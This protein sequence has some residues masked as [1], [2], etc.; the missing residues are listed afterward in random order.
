M[1]CYTI[2]CYIIQCDTIIMPER[3]RPPNP[4]AGGA[5]RHHS[6][7]LQ[8]VLKVYQ[9][10]SL[11]YLY[12]LHCCLVFVLLSCFM[13]C[14]VEPL[15]H[16]YVILLIVVCMFYFTVS[17]H[18]FDAQHVH[19]RVSNPGSIARAHFNMHSKSSNLPGQGPFLPDWSF[20]NWPYPH[21]QIH[22]LKLLDDNHIAGLHLAG[23]QNMTREVPCAFD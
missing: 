17:S 23:K 22:R 8:S 13:L 19:S 10:I 21:C 2:I 9:S 5:A 11:S 16:V 7:G 6:H 4:R 15:F 14:C 12:C 3:H 1:L 20:E 18:K